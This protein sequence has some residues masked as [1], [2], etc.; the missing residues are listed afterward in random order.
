[1]RYRTAMG[2][3][4]FAVSLAIL[5]CKGA[6]GAGRPL[7]L[8]LVAVLGCACVRSPKPSLDPF[9]LDPAH[10]ERASTVEVKLP[11]P[12]GSLPGP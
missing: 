8:L 12:T 2:V 6:K 1:M 10:A 5:G 4:G 7:G 11:R 9:R 3:I